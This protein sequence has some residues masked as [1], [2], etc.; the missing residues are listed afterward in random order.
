MAFD[1]GLPAHVVAA[2][3][4]LN[5]EDALVNCCEESPRGDPEKPAVNADLKGVGDFWNSGFN[6]SA[7]P[8]DPAV[9]LSSGPYIVRDIVPDV[10]MTLVRNRDYVWGPEPYLD[11]ITVQFT[12]AVPAAVDALRNGQADIIAPQPSAGSEAIF[13]GLDAQG[14]TV[15]RYSQS[16]YDHLDLN[17]AGP[18]ADRKSARRS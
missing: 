12:G 1:V 13:G 4:G 7:I 15:Q 14:I 6:T 11:E 17:F 9:Y 2:K 8:D 3:G 10:S 16:G 18:F 5:D